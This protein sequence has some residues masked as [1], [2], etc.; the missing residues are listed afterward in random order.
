MCLLFTRPHKK[1]CPCS[2]TFAQTRLSDSTT[3]AQ[4]LKCPFSRLLRACLSCSMSKH[5]PPTCIHIFQIYMCAREVSPSSSPAVILKEARDRRLSSTCRKM[6]PQ[7]YMP[8]RSQVWSMPADTGGC[9]VLRPGSTHS[10]DRPLG[11]LECKAHCKSM[12]SCMLKS[13]VKNGT[14]G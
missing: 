4:V 6:L 9:N 11:T 12:G 10:L 7:V 5:A 1:T 8:A 3:F 2:S 14:L 13:L